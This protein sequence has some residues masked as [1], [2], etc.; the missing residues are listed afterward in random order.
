MKQ[1]S[2]RDIEKL[3][4]R[5]REDDRVPH[6]ATSVAFYSA[7]IL[8]DRLSMLQEA[9]PPD[10]LHAVAVK[11][12]SSPEVLRLIAEQGCGLEA[13]SF[14]EVELAASAGIPPQRIV[15]DSPVKTRAEIQACHEL[16][17]GM[18]VNANSLEE[19]ERY[20][21][22]FSGTLG[23]RINPLVDSDAPDLWN[24]SQRA[25]KFGVDI[26]RESDIILSCIEH[27]GISGLHV[28][29]GSGIRDFSANLEAI[30]RIVQL[31]D[32]VNGARE[33]RSAGEPL[34][35]IDIGGGI[36]FEGMDGDQGIMTFTNAIRE[37]T[38]LFDRY[39][40]ITEF[41]KFVHND[42]GYVV[43]DIEYILPG[44][45]AEDASTIFIHV[46]ADMFVRKVYSDLP[47]DF[48]Y[49]VIKVSGSTA[50]DRKRYHIA[51]PLC[52]AGDF[53]GHDVELPELQPG[54]KLVI[55]RAGA[56]TLSM[57]SAHCS[58]KVPPLVIV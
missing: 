31:A 58:R 44:Y 21:E 36:L 39:R 1:L 16:F 20:P 51:G 32:R 10:T 14:D 18:T 40:V 46:G 7:D 48:P 4:C 52:F 57:W 55:Q 47:L 54:D 49:S 41:G 9:F 19:L 11:A 45:S 42:A 53:L 38:G 3:Y 22:N 8:S 35:W 25:S 5:A 27:P 17:P 56:N 34:T 26:R 15:F 50:P 33:A 6:E 37:R 43:S 30:S 2:D 29:V 12:N 24:V 28:H 23:I 13:A